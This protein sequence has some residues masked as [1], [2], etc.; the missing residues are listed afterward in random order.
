MFPFAEQLDSEHGMFIPTL[1][2]SD[3][4]EVLVMEMQF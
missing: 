1:I 3:V 4:N 2:F